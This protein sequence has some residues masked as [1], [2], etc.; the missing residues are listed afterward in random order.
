MAPLRPPTCPSPPP[1]PPPPPPS[2]SPSSPRRRRRFVPRCTRGPSAAPLEDSSRSPPPTPSSTRP[3][4]RT[5][6]RPYCRTDSIR[7]RSPPPPVPTESPPES[8]D[9]PP[10]SSSRPRFFSRF[11]PWCGCSGSSENAAERSDWTE[12]EDCR[13]CDPGD[14][15]LHSNGLPSTPSAAAQMVEL[16]SEF[17]SK[18][19]RF[20][21]FSCNEILFLKK[22]KK[23][24]PERWVSGLWK[25]RSEFY[26]DME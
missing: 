13:I 1:S 4:S 19:R 14:Y 24:N 9:P 11:C 25:R 16:E 3:A 10:L 21:T 6:P 20:I 15:C 12:Y 7:R 8:D 22:K 5:P 23:E 17:W 2:P 18:R 26:I